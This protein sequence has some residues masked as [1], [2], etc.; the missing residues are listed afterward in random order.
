MKNP[1]KSATFPHSVPVGVCIAL[2][3]AP[4]KGSP[5]S[6]IIRPLIEAVVVPCAKTIFPTSSNNPLNKRL[7]KFLF[8]TLGFDSATNLKGGDDKNILGK[9][10][11]L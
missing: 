11:F 7:S 2:T 5:F 6:S 8:I 10:S 1:S 9:L 4:G 3:V